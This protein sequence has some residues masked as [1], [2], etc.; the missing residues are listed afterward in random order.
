M[1]ERNGRIAILC[2]S[3]SKSGILATFI[4]TVRETTTKA[5]IFIY[6]CDDDPDLA[7]YKIVQGACPEVNF[8]YGPNLGFIKA[9][10]YMWKKNPGYTLYYQANDDQECLVKD[11]DLRFLNVVP[12]DGIVGVSCWPGNWSNKDSCHIHAVGGEWLDA[13]GYWTPLGMWHQHMD[14]ITRDLATAVERF[15]LFEEVLIWHNESPHPDRH[16][17]ITLDD[18]IYHEWLHGDGFKTAVVALKGK[19]INENTPDIPG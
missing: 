5:D 7:G 9:M 16:K 8:T 15:V 13:V 14:D 18:Q 17:T 19:M 4:A 11:W 2:P 10:D 3:G 1:S 12:P 6:V